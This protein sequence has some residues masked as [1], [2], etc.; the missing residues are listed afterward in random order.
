M[1]EPD[2]F[3]ASGDSENP[4]RKPTDFNTDATA[5]QANADRPGTGQANADQPGTG[6]PGT[7]KPGKGQSNTD[8]Q[9]VSASQSL[10][11]SS[12]SPDSIEG[13]FLQ[14]LQQPDPADRAEFLSKSCGEDQD[15]MRRVKALLRAYDDAGSF[16]EEPAGGPR[17][18]S[19]VSL[20]FLKPTD[21]EG[22]LGT[23]GPYEV[24]EVIGRG[25]MGVVLRAVDLKLNRIVAVKA[26]LPELAANPNSR[27]RF[28]REAQAAA[29]ISHPHVV[30]IHAVDDTHED[31][32]GKPVPPYLVMECV[33]GQSLQQKLDRVGT[34]RLAEILRIGRQIAEGLA[35]AHKQGVIHRDI[36]PAN[37]LLENG[38][39]RVKI[40]D[41][42]LARAIDD[43]TVTRTGEVS[44]TP[45][46]MSPEQAC[47]E[48]VDQ[49]SDLFS[50]G[51][52]M[53]AMCTGHS[54][55]RGDSIAHV[56]KRVTQDTPRPIDGQN[57]EI[58][59]WLI[60]IIT[61]LLQKNPEHRF[62]SAQGVVTILDQHLSRIQHPTQSGSHSLINQQMPASGTGQSVVNHSAQTAPAPHA[63]AD[64]MA[65]WQIRLSNVL[66]WI[67]V[68]IL[69]CGLW[70]LISLAQ[71]RM[72]HLT[73]FPSAKPEELTLW[74]LGLAA[75]FL[76][77]A[78]VLRVSPHTSPPTGGSLLAWFLVGGPIG[79]VAWLL[80]RESHSRHAAG[81]ERNKPTDR[82]APSATQ[83]TAASASRASAPPLTSTG[84]LGLSG[85]VLVPNWMRSL[86]RIWL[87]LASAFVVL[88]IVIQ[89]TSNFG[90]GSAEWMVIFSI[91]AFGSIVMAI[92]LSRKAVTREVMAIA[93]FLG[94]G[95]LGLLLYLL[96]K[97]GLQ[98][99]PTGDVQTPHSAT[100]VSQPAE[101]SSNV[102]PW[103]ATRILSALLLMLPA[104]LG[105][106][107]SVFMQAQPDLSKDLAANLLELF[108]Y[109][110]VFAGI[111]VAQ[112]LLNRIYHQDRFP[113]Q[114][115][116]L[117]SGAVMASMA[118]GWF[119]ATAFRIPTSLPE[120]LTAWHNVIGFA[121]LPTMI[122]ILF[123]VY[124][125]REV[126]TSRLDQASGGDPGQAH[127]PRTPST[128]GETATVDQS[129][130][131][132]VD[133]AASKHALQD[134]ATH[135]AQVKPSQTVGVQF[136]AAIVQVPVE[137]YL[138]YAAT[139]R[140]GLVCVLFLLGGA[141]YSL[142]SLA[143]AL[144]RAE[145]TNG[146]ISRIATFAV[147]QLAAWGGATVAVWYAW[148][149][150]LRGWGL[151]S[152]VMFG[153]IFLGY[154]WAI[155][156]RTNVFSQTL[157]GIAILPTVGWIPYAGFVLSQCRT[158]PQ[159]QT[160][161]VP[162]SQKSGLQKWW[163]PVLVIGF[164]FYLLYAN[165]SRRTV[166]LSPQDS[167]KA[168][169]FVAQRFHKPVISVQ[170][171]GKGQAIV[172][173][174]PDDG[175]DG[176][177]HLIQG[178]NGLWELDPAHH[179]NKI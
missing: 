87:L 44:G 156:L 13:L 93:L 141:I 62:Q 158:L 78:L 81:M 22:V 2:K 171:I 18:T 152:S 176:V 172:V 169:E 8:E 19:E 1:T 164:S 68:P 148:K 3:A 160:L 43:I 132:A 84:L 112:L 109:P 147:V 157:I 60:E 63:V 58:P 49:R 119:W 179:A 70:W 103:L 118:V 72:W 86:S 115:Y 36:K 90:I 140:L 16:L 27:R 142:I 125:G 77:P 111:W 64:S 138:H 55:F 101:E 26:L 4:A 167:Q 116:A 50:L 150:P 42:G 14:A 95:P 45:Q 154:F 170:S 30:T 37:I 105:G 127:V 54:P 126:G 102:A 9:T 65:R 83:S 178:A 98:P 124:V 122:W 51:C 100:T 153:C 11:A 25:G 177:I 61:C 145:S 5:G 144:L 71:G 88:L 151:L 66:L 135:G 34:L 134:K 21:K 143:P 52:V 130:S 94:L 165:S 114:K 108:K 23:I 174:R 20:S 35:A 89:N 12:I 67:G 99:E 73:A 166:A 104:L 28:L 123:C 79:I 17:P 155:A 128:T 46:Y 129:F 74:A 110:M 85:K 91:A 120:Q 47:G 53:Y 10:A 41:F 146:L 175:G 168:V 32:N 24:L 59:T 96:V 162:T 39:E 159:F 107:L 33:V 6:Q 29:A 48:R 136:G 76:L 75:V 139:K 7:G 31:T 149:F 57:P 131:N 56:I 38:V 121:V 80:D 137:N 92:L 161:F 97:D 82:H 173:I 117:A 113:L 15:L 69:C 163:L 106:F 40:T 133:R